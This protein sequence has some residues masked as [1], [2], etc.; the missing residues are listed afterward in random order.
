[1]TTS[2]GVVELQDDEE[3]INAVINKADH[4]MYLA[5]QKRLKYLFYTENLTP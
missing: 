4:A 5:K 1:M 2:F 3:D